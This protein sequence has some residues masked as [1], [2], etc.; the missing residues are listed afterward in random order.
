MADEDADKRQH[1]R[2]DTRV[3]VE[4]S[5]YDT[6]QGETVLQ[7]A[8]SRNVSAGGLLVTLDRP[9]EISAF[10]MVHFTLPGGGEPLDFIAKVMRVKESDSP[11]MYDI[12]LQFV[13]IIIGDFGK[14]KEYI[15]D[16]TGK[17]SEV[18]AFVHEVERAADTMEDHDKAIE[19]LE[20]SADKKTAAR[21]YNKRGLA[22]KKEGNF[23]GAIED[24]N[25]A[26]ELDPQSAPAYNN[27]ARAR[28]WTDHIEDAI[29]DYT[30]AI[31][32]LE[33]MGDN[34]N[35]AMA[36]TNRGNARHVACDFD[37]AIADMNKAM[38]MAPNLSRVSASLALVMLEWKGDFKKARQLIDKALL[39]T[40][41]VWHIACKALI[42]LAAGERKEAEAFLRETEGMETDVPGHKS[43]RTA[44]S[45][46]YILNE[47][48]Y[49][50]LKKK[51][52]KK[53]FE[54][55]IKEHELNDYAHAGLII[56]MRKLRKREDSRD[57]LKEL[58]TRQ[59]TLYERVIWLVDHPPV[60]IRLR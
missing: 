43:W 8:E 20:A 22:H 30:K 36:Y 37:G 48:E 52:A 56:S 17:A 2:L 12:G 51:Q 33:A 47:R 31:E 42:E 60:E 10:A 59:K 58:R 16:E 24:Y 38:E 4:V 40:R 35:A 28:V 32:I 55:A 27:R 44:V 7:S 46:W 49:S 53:T 14:V 39:G 13:D 41:D 6:A 18:E 45:G 15:L 1:T 23:K 26:I 34:L 3:K 11:D 5:V 57:H 50:E 25:R 54:Q 29:K 9:L 21:I 19:S